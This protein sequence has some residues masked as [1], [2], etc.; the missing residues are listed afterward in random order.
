MWL[1][2]YPAMSNMDT[3]VNITC[4]K[5]HGIKAITAV[6]FDIYFVPDFWQR[7]AGPTG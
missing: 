2:F 6:L 5:M 4:D 7:S 1:T 3:N